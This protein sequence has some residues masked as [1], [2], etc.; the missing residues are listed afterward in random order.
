MSFEDFG[1]DQNDVEL[2]LSYLPMELI[3]T[4]NCPLVIIGN[5][6]QVKNFL[7]YVRGKSST[8]LCVS[9]S[10][11]NGNSENIELDKEESN[12]RFS[13]QGEH[14][15]RSVSKVNSFLAFS[16]KGESNSRFSDQ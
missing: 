10:P 11:I 12:L 1:I 16:E 8:R 2:E 4:I 14:S 13:E 6:R 15:S 9:T 7:T 5:D 3:S